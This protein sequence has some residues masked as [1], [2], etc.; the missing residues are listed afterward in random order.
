MGTRR[1]STVPLLFATL[2]IGFLSASQATQPVDTETRRL[3]D[4]LK[5]AGFEVLRTVAN[6]SGRAFAV[7][8]LKAK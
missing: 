7:V 6:W 2:N 8:A 1:T 4:E 5:A 3:I